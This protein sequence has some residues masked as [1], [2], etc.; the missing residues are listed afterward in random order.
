MIDSVTLILKSKCAG[1]R[2]SNNCQ[3]TEGMLFP[4]V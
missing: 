2:A 3:D 4:Y 1:E